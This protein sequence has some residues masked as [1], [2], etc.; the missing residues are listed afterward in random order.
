MTWDY[1]HQVENRYALV[2]LQLGAL[3]IGSVLIAGDIYLT[4]QGLKGFLANQPIITEL[5]GLVY[6]DIVRVYAG[7]SYPLCLASTMILGALCLSGFFI[8]LGLL[9]CIPSPFYHVLTFSSGT[10]NYVLFVGLE[11]VLML[12]LQ[13]ILDQYRQAPQALA[14]N[15]LG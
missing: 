6:L 13:S 9:T 2:G 15:I 1:G 10:M 12:L 3:S 4:I 14:L 8:L 7:S 5:L 11:I